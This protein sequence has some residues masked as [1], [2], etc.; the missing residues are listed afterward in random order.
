MGNKNSQLNI[1][2]YIFNEYIF[3]NN[4]LTEKNDVMK[5]IGLLV[6]NKLATKFS[7][8]YDLMFNHQFNR[9][10]FIC[11]KMCEW[12]PDLK[13]YISK[14]DFTD[15]D[16][17]TN[18]AGVDSEL[19]KYLKYTFQEG[20]Y[21]AEL[22]SKHS[23]EFAILE[24]NSSPEDSS[25]QNYNF[26]FVGRKCQK[27]YIKF[28]EE[29]N[30]VKESLHIEIE[31]RI[32]YT[33]GKPDN[34]VIFKPF[35]QMVFSD[36]DKY[37]KYID[38]WVQSLPKYY[39]YGMIP[40]LSILLYGEPGTGKSTFCKALAHH[41]GIKNITSISPDYFSET[42]DTEY[43]KSKFAPRATSKA[44][45]DYNQTIYS[46]DD[47]DCIGRSREKDESSE[48]GRVTSSLLEFL[49]NPPSFYFKANDGKYYQISIVCA[50]TNYYDRLDSAVKRFGRF[51]LTIPMHRF[52]KDEAE[53]MCKLYDLSLKDIYHEKYDKNTTFSPA[54]IQALCM[55]NV[56]KKLKSN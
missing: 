51:D 56:D 50:T 30:R 31:E 53:E 38:N 45:I 43:R 11:K 41:L 54:Q 21:F 25:Y 39:E 19:L 10:N 5:N 27:N 1:S 16:I 36:K 22:K 35:E 33:N 18:K 13:K 29:F 9:Y 14:E 37:I 6:D 40:K 23:D 12:N 8:F 49:D 48:N 34:I 4:E 46:I 44:S 28:N 2:K 32:H 42:I 17:F 24:V 55:E 7:N 3:N 47:I 20:I 52:T 26:Y 15:N